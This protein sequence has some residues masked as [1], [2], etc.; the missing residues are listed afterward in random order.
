[1]DLLKRK[2]QDLSK[3]GPGFS[4]AL[5]IAIVSYLLN[6]FVLQGLGAATIAILLGIILGNVYFKQPIL[7]LGTAWSEK[8]LLE[9]S[10]MFLGATVT[11]QT[12]G[13]LGWSGV[14]FIILQM[15]ATITFVLFVGKKLGFSHNIT[16]LMASGNA[17]CGSSAIA[18]VEPVIGADTG[19]KRT[20]IAM[21]NLMGTILMLTLPLIGT[22]LFGTNDLLRGALIGG[23][24]QSVGQV[25]ASAT[26]VNSETTTLATLFKIMRIILLVFV[27]LYFGTRHQKERKIETSPSDIKLK[28]QSFLPW[29]VMGFLVLCTLDTF[30][31]FAPELSTTAKFISG[32]CETIALAAIG[33]RLNLVEFVK[34]GK[35]LLIYG[36]ST[37]LFQVI[38]AFILISLLLK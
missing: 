32:W 28:R 13:K 19:E 33:L 12:I 2:T 1:M 25:V 29:Y 18:A 14:G 3:I 34:A 38:L 16:V 17:V 9:F 6:R 27:V 30:V 21:V 7:F 36:I 5:V 31:H 10:V 24:E 23:T 8:K 26:M 20:S 15:I 35:K 22:W 11:F 4:M 37:L